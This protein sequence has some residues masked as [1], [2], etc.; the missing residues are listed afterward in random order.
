[1]QEYGGGVMVVEKVTGRTLIPAN[2]IEEEDLEFISRA[3]IP[4]I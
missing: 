2:Q 1:M 3:E 4:D